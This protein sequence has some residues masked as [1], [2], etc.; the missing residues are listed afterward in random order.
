MAHIRQKKQTKGRENR[1]RGNS[2]QL[3]G[4]LVATRKVTRKKEV[5]LLGITR[6]I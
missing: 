4:I 1:R 3:A 5:V 2:I 6:T